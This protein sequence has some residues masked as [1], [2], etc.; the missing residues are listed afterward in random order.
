LLH[1][2]TDLVLQHYLVGAGF[3][4]APPTTLRNHEERK[5]F[6]KSLNEIWKKNMKEDNAKF[7]GCLLLRMKTIGI[8][9]GTA[10]VKPKIINGIALSSKAGDMGG[11]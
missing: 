4:A 1:G 3:V 9:T 8:S 7:Y 5:G 11:K 2:F 6:R 10:T